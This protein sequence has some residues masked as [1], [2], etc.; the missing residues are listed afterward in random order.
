MSRIGQRSDRAVF[1]MEEGTPRY[2]AHCQKDHGNP[3]H[4]KNRH[5]ERSEEPLF[6]D[7]WGCGRGFISQTPIHSQTTTTL[8]DLV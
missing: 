6:E 1:F 3:K 8:P 7:V 4:P 2:L 5:S